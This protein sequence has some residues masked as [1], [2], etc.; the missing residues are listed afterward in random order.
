MSY[1]RAGAGGRIVKYFLVQQ[2]C[3]RLTKILPTGER[4]RIYGGHM[5]IPLESWRMHGWV[6]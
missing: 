1:K 4:Y 2:A 6:S 3:R 5:G